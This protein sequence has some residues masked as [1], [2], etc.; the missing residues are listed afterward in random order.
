MVDTLFKDL[1]SGSKIYALVKKDAEL[2]YFE[3]TI[4]TKGAQRMDMP[5]MQSGQIPMTRSV[6]D[7][8]YSIDGKN[9]TD[10]VDI[11]ASMFPT[12]KPGA[13][14]LVAT[15]K[16]PIIRELRATLSKAEDYLKSVEVEVPRNK[17]RI[18]DCKDL[19]SLLDVEYA[20]KQEFELRLKKLED[21]SK[22]TNKLLNQILNKL[23]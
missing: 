8:T 5:Q 20:E 12:E 11:T 10:A 7:V 13:I 19:I 16:E 4:V 1:N 15:E 3:G 22:E 17:K 6:I 21:G 2:Q 14:T 18:E 23:K 9:Y